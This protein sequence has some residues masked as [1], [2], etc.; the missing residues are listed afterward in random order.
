MGDHHNKNLPIVQTDKWGTKGHLTESQQQAYDQF[1]Q[2]ATE[3][4]LTIAKFKVESL[5]NVSLRYLRARNF[6]VENA[7]HLLQE[8]VDKKKTLN[9]AHWSTRS[10]DECAHCNVEALKKWYPHAQ[11]GYD[12]FNRPVLFEHSGAVDGYAIYQMS[13][14]ENL[15]NYHWYSM[16]TELNQMFENAPRE[17]GAE[18]IIST[19][20]VID[21]QGFN[22]HHT[23]SVVLDHV[24]AM[25]ALDNV[26]YPEVLG[27]MLVINAPWLAGNMDYMIALSF[28]LFLLFSLF[29][30]I[31]L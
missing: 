3:E 24:K 28:S 31:Y 11:F 26:C 29:L 30:F 1:R 17:P 20:V 12:K 22:M 10:P 15:I 16:E 27:K 4:N 5:E 13:T 8:C 2:L 7:L 23:S 18:P 6:N 25:V 14:L 19:C 21:L 9:S